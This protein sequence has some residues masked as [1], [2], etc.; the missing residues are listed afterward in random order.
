MGLCSVGNIGRIDVVSLELDLVREL[1]GSK[2]R[3]RWVC[4]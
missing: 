3:M 1:E 2:L 4:P